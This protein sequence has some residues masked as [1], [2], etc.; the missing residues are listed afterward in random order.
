M[1][2]R[3]AARQSIALPFALADQSG[4]RPTASQ[5]IAYKLRRHGVA[6]SLVTTGMG[7]KVVIIEPKVARRA[8][9]MPAG[10]RQQAERGGWL[11]LR[12]P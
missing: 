5:V 10:G 4:D 7:A 2:S 3:G 11:R 6:S 8:R 1:A 12:G 9:P